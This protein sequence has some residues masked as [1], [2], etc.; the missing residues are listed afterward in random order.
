M[1]DGDIRAEERR[2]N[3]GAFAVTLYCTKCHTAWHESVWHPEGRCPFKDCDGRL[4]RSA[5]LV[6]EKPEPKRRRTY[7][8]LD[9][10]RRDD[11]A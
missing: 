5:P 9:L 10:S 6:V 4:T 8:L 2:E 11:T 1:P 3:A 7:P